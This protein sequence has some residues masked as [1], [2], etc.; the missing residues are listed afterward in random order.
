[1]EVSCIL[2][3][4]HQGLQTKCIVLNFPTTHR[5]NNPEAEH[6]ICMCLAYHAISEFVCAKSQLRL[7][8]SCLNKST[9]SFSIPDEDA[10][11][12]ICLIEFGPLLLPFPVRT[13]KYKQYIWC[14]KLDVLEHWYARVEGTGLVGSRV[15]YHPLAV[16]HLSC[17][18]HSWR[19]SLCAGDRSG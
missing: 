14:R 16:L 4:C 15:G 1:M 6:D 18:W 7:P 3:E 17:V 8:P 12:A 2:Q 10:H 5:C 11:K 13:G 19:C 9:S